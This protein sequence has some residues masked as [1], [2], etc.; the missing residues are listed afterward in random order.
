MHILEKFNLPPQP[1]TPFGCGHINTTYQV[2]G[3]G[4]RP[5]LLQKI[6]SSV[7]P[8]IPGL[9]HNIQV[10][11][12]HIQ[13]KLHQAGHPRPDR[14]GLTCLPTV[15]GKYYVTD[16]SGDAWRLLRFIEDSVTHEQLDDPKLAQSGA[17]AFGEFQRQVADI[18]PGLLNIT[19]S[20]FHHL[21][22]R[23]QA[24]EE[25]LKADSHGRAKELTTEADYINLAKE[26]LCE[27]QRLLD[28]GAIPTR[29]THNDT[30][31][32]NVLFDT[33]GNGLCAIDLD[34]VMPGAFQFDFSDTLRTAACTAAEDETDLKKVEID[35]RL[36]EAV[37][38]G[39][40]EPMQDQL[41]QTEKELLAPAANLMP[42]M[43]GLRFLTDYLQ[44]DSY[45]KIHRPK[46]NLDRARCQLKLSQSIERQEKKLRQIIMAEFGYKP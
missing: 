31:L 28:S 44:G 14:A 15:D 3:E 19:I 7:F 32:N 29:I 36:F 22:S 27:T 12:K 35:L 43:V 41:T 21:P 18:D 42:F 9:M 23:L 45:F 13:K 24:F 46:H 33:D 34:T 11:T 16:E 1:L 6:N 38:A 40:L 4:N 39:Y 30:K 20:H 10:V 17:R 26:K 8:D 25:A 5:Y 37:A 2:T